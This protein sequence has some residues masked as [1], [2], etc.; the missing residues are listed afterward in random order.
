MRNNYKGRHTPYI[1]GNLVPR[2]RRS[3]T[4]HPYPGLTAGPIDCRP[5]GPGHAVNRSSGALWRLRPRTAIPGR[6]GMHLFK[7]DSL[8]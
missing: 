4:L 3:T 5:F 7:A 8:P 2:L 6:G 1:S